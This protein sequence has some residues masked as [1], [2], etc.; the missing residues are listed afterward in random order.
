MDNT[1]KKNILILK[2]GALGDVVRS[3]F[4]AESLYKEKNANIYW[5]TS[6]AA[7]T[8]I[9]HN[10]FIKKISSDIK[11]FY[12][13]DFD[14]LYNLEDE[15]NFSELVHNLKYKKIIGAYISSDKLTYTSE[16][17]EWFDMGI[18][19]SFGK[20]K[21]DAL[22]KINTRSHSQIF[23]DIFKVTKPIPKIYYN[24]IGEN[25][26]KNNALRIL[27]NPFA[28][29][30]WKSKELN[31]NELY[32][33]IRML[34]ENFLNDNE[35]EIGLLGAGRDRIKNLQ[36]QKDLTTEGFSVEVYNTDSELN[37]L[38][39]TIEKHCDILITTDSLALHIGNGLGKKIIAFF[40]P[41][42]AAEIDL[43]YGGSKIISTLDDYCNYS[44]D[45]DNSDITAL[46]IFKATKNLQ[47][48]EN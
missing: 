4:F 2:F 10:P 14:I 34:N 24:K 32:K 30:R 15:L 37:D 21:A 28:G 26:I 48:G 36:I 45:C 20:Q 35:L 3:S 23:S 12:N 43:F 18:I 44:K 13:I 6:E 40:A 19:S 29:D 46:K 38:I 41:T 16:C 11:D 27:I 31:L 9:A 42:S 8:L 17:S 7:I 5:F 25:S 22:K 47:S 1:I 33:L 39:H